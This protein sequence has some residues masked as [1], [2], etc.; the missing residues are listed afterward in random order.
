[1]S[2]EIFIKI[3]NNSAT[4]AEKLC[5][6]SEIES[7]RELR[8]EYIQYKTLYTLAHCPNNNKIFPTKDNFEDFWS[9]LNSSGNR[10]V[11]HL[12]FR[13]AAIFVVALALGFT[14]QY[15]INSKKEIPVYSSH[16]EYTSEKGAVSAIHLEDGSSIWLSS[17][18][19]IVISKKSTGE[20]SA[21]LNGEAYFDMVPDPK[22]NFV[23][24]LGY[25]KVRDIGT[26]FDIRAYQC[27]QLIYAALSDGQIDL[28]KSESVP[29]LS[30]KPG[31]YMQFNKQSN[32]VVVSKQDPSIATAWKDGKFV[33]IH[34]TLGEICH[35]LECWYNVQI[36]IHDKILEN[37]RYT[38]V[39]KRTTTVKLVLE[40]LS[41]TDKI[42]YKITD[43]KEA[44]DIVYIY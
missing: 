10:P 4:D 13:Y 9:Q 26:K 43:R 12:W 8:E 28:C 14:V 36:I 41:L 16:I 15:L 21:V 31:E 27:E 34:K 11:F 19:K 7:N 2:E 33:F 39:I 23:V 20:M 17:G 38:S 18:S 5:F 1:M 44:K 30:L 3:I 32:Q 24:D 22:R 29:V 37:T 25:F 6:Y 42:N 40:M 35:E